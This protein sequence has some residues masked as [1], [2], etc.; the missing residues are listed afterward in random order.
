MA[1]L[2]PCIPLPRRTHH[3]HRPVC[4]VH[5]PHPLRIL[6]LTQ[7]TKYHFIIIM[8]H[9]ILQNFIINVFLLAISEAIN[10]YA[11]QDSFQNSKHYYIESYG[12]FSIAQIYL[13]RICFDIPH[14]AVGYTSQLS[15]PVRIL[16]FINMMIQ[17]FYF[18]DFTPMAIATI[19]GIILC[20]I[21]RKIACKQIKKEENRTQYL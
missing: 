18:L 12:W 16:P 14:A 11:K 17:F 4:Y 2:L 1:D 5:R 8:A 10:K 6:H 15:I 3:S 13:I 20:F 21:E 19:W 7:A 9:V